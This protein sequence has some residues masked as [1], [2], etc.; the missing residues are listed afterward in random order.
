MFPSFHSRDGGFTN[1]RDAKAVSKHFEKW[2]R[3]TFPG[4]CFHDLRGSHETAL[5][6]GGVPVR[7]S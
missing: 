4:L 7:M 2:S 3:R 6:D 5:L 1:L